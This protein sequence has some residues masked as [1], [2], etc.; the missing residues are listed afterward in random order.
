MAASS[1]VEPGVGHDPPHVLARARSAGSSENSKCWVRLRMVGSTFCGSVVASTNVD[2]VGRLLQRLQQRVR[3]RRGEHV[4]L[5]EDV[6]LGAPGRPDRRPADEVA[7]GVDAV[8]RRRVELEQVVG[9][10]PPRS[11]RSSRTSPHGSPSR[12]VR[13]VEDLGQD[14]GGGGLAGAPRAAEEVGLAGGVARDRVAER[15]DDVVLAPHLGEPAGPVAPVERLLGHRRPAYR[16]VRRRPEGVAGRG[17]SASPS[18]PWAR[19]VDGR[20]PDRPAPGLAPAIPCGIAP[21]RWWDGSAWSPWVWDDGDLRRPIRPDRARGSPTSERCAGPAARPRPPRW[22][23]CSRRQPDRGRT[24]RL[25]DDRGRAHRTGRPGASRHRLPARR[26][27]T[28]RSGGVRA[29]SADD[30]GFRFRPIDL[31]ARAR[32]RRR[33]VP[34]GRRLGR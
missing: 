34:H 3:R 6:H 9:A 31:A 26:R 5:V 22:W 11:R 10:C 29:A 2:V 19:H 15:P 24:R 7:H 25:G 32:R 21:L 18:L 8:V 14:A 30:L 27:G 1:T 23:R 33:H 17:R 13:A 28:R 4:D 16:W 20:S 12:Q